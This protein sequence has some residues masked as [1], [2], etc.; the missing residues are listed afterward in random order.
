MRKDS[1]LMVLLFLFVA[2]APFPSTAQEPVSTSMPAPIATA[3]LVAE[4]PPGCAGANLVYHPQLQ[5]V[6][7]LGCLSASTRAED[8]HVIW[9]W[10]GEQWHR[11]A[12][13]GPE[14]LVLGGAAYDEKRNMVVQYGG[15]SLEKNHCG[16]ETWEW[17]GQ[18]WAEKERQSPA[19]CDHLEMVYDASRQ[20]IIL[21]GG[22]DENTNLNTETWSWDGSKWTSISPSGPAGRAHFGFV[23]DDTH[24][25]I[26]LYGG[27]SDKILDDLWA[28]KNGEWQSI[29]LPGPGPL[30]HVGMALDSEEALILFGGAGSTST[31]T[32]LTDKTWRLTNGSWSELNLETHPSKRGSP[33][34]AYD[35]GRKRIVLYGGFASNRADLNDT[36]EWDGRQW[37]CVLNCQ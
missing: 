27:Y 17:D 33:A 6:L 26:L 28:W 34:M 37:I 5:E 18:A 8:T 30:S 13:G 31:F 10:N 29:D 4:N 3:T 1:I 25:Q 24:E 16:R 21:F 12:E 15:Y 32:S 35:R 20:E 36:W 22:G 7:M 9:G 2:C 19:P 14:L 23:Y 11:V